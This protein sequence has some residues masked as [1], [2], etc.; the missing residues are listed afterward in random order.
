MRYGYSDAYVSKLSVK[1]GFNI[2]TSYEYE[3]RHVDG[4]KSSF[5]LYILQAPGRIEDDEVEQ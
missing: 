3:S 1:Y 5:V 2:V 4:S